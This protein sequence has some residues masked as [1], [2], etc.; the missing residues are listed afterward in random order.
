MKA[1]AGS[2]GYPQFDAQHFCDWYEANG[3]KRKNGKPVQNWKQTVLTWL[4][5]EK[6]NGKT[7]DSS[8]P[9]GPSDEQSRA[10]LDEMPIP[11][12]P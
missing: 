1:Y 9:P 11:V 4:K 12:S 5:R 2:R 7:S 10:A 3:W 6:A 8:D